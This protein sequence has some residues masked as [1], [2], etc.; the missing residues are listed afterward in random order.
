MSAREA[1]KARAFEKQGN[2]WAKEYEAEFKVDEAHSPL[3]LDLIVEAELWA[4]AKAELAT[5]ERFCSGFSGSTGKD[6]KG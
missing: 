3:N 6:T 5:D 2:Q 1:Y 4:K